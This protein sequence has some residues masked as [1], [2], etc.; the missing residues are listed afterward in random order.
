ML[1]DYEKHQNLWYLL[2]ERISEAAR[3]S[4]KGEGFYS[5]YSALE[6][7][8]RQLLQEYFP[9][10]DR[11]IENL[12][13]AC[14][15]AVQEEEDRDWHEPGSIN[16]NYCPLR[17]PNSLQCDDNYSL[18]MHL[19]DQLRFNNVSAAADTCIAIANV[20][21]FTDKEYEKKIP[22]QSVFHIWKSREVN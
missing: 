7:L 15:A 22:A 11:Q 17:W 14:N 10:E 19:I 3:G 13:F 4:Y 21:P 12:C 2:A 9:E 20:K 16:C 5:G 18:Y 6:K 1:F 8:K